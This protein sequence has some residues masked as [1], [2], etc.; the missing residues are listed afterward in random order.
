MLRVGHG[1]QTRQAVIGIILAFSIISAWIIAHISGVFFYTWGTHSVITAPALVALNCWLFVGL[2][3]VAHDCMHGSLVP[4]R[5][6][7]NR[8]VG[9]LC[10]SLYAGF[11]FG[12]LNRKHHLHHRHSGTARDPDFDPRPP[13]GFFRWYAGFFA[14]YFGWTQFVFLSAVS[15]VYLL[16]FHVSYANLLAF[17]ALPA[18]ASS[19][20]LFYFGTYLPHKPGP[21]DFTDRHRTRSN[22][23]TWLTSLLTCFHFGYHHEHHLRPDVPWWRLPAVRAKL[24]ARQSEPT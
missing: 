14:E 10:L 5:P 20:Q 2:F 16:L 22:E 8:F 23:W 17:W 11:K 19:L 3:I 6:A 9:Q 18:I 4:Y 1:T 12:H 24:E 21:S 13:H 15:A 7:L